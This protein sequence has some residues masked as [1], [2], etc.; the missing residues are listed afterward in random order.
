MNF[1]GFFLL[2]WK[3]RFWIKNRAYNSATV[4]STTRKILVCDMKSCYKN[5]FKIRSFFKIRKKISKN[6]IRIEK[7]HVDSENN[8]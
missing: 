5:I 6:V 1:S 2:F 4:S 7:I 8:Q 3:Y